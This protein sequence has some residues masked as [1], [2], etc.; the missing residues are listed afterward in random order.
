MAFVSLT[1]LRVRSI[2]FLPPFLW[3]TL[4]TTR[5][6]RRSPGFLGGEILRESGNVYWTMTAWNDPASMNA[7]RTQGA[8]GAVMPKLLDWCDEAAVAHWHQPAAELPNWQQA[9]FIMTKDGRPSKVKHPSPAHLA[10]EIPPPRVG[11]AEATLR[12]TRRK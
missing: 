1:R 10:N 12:P 3:H 8:H 5:Q 7:F 9:H 6:A 4:K 11:R 2:G